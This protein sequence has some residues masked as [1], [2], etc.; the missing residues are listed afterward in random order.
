M[1]IRLHLSII[2][3]ITFCGLAVAQTIDSSGVW[4]IVP[5]TATAV[6]PVADTA[7][8]GMKSD[9]LR[10]SAPDTAAVHGAKQPE[11]SNLKLIKRSYNSRQ[12]LLLASGM[13]I[14]VI[15]MMTAAQQWNPE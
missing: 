4:K 9:T 6:S 3:I 5:D 14:F 13:M 8:G 15:A 2:P 10:S 1:K 7:P 12:Q 11:A